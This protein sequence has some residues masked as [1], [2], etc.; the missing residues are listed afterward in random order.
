MCASTQVTL[1][2]V[3]SKNV[4]KTGPERRTSAIAIDTTAVQEPESRVIAIRAT[5]LASKP[6]T[7]A[8][9]STGSGRAASCQPRLTEVRAQVLVLEKVEPNRG[10]GRM[11]IDGE[12]LNWSEGLISFQLVGSDVSSLKWRLSMR[13]I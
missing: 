4:S 1:T 12:Y 10:Y 6:S 3:P 5:R 7:R 8:V 11:M 13:F 9:V 2:L